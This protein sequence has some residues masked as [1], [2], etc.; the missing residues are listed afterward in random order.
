M[1]LIM[2]YTYYCWSFHTS[3]TK[4]PFL[5]LFLSVVDFRE[6]FRTPG[7]RLSFIISF[8]TGQTSLVLFLHTFHTSSLLSV[9]FVW[10]IP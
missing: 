7:L 8:V 3:V 6:D 1:P 10:S 4:E 5:C 2:D 9:L